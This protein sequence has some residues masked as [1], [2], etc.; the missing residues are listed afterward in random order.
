MTATLVRSWYPWVVGLSVLYLLSGCGS[1]TRRASQADSAEMAH[2][3]GNNRPS[4]GS[5]DDDDG[6]RAERA[7]RSD[8]GDFDRGESDRGD[9]RR[10]RAPA[11]MPFGDA[12][13]VSPRVRRRY[14]GERRVNADNFFDAPANEGSLWV[15]DGQGNYYFTKNRNRAIGDLITVVM[16]EP[17]VR[18]TLAEVK[19]TLS[20]AERKMELSFA[21]DRIKAKTL[22]DP[23]PPIMPVP[24][25][26]Y[27][28]E[29]KEG[30]KDERAPAVAVAPSP[31][32]SP[33]ASLSAEAAVAKQKEIEQMRRDKL[34]KMAKATM[35]D[36]DIVPYVGLKP[37]DTMLAEIVDRYPN[38]NFKIRG[39][40]KIPYRS[41]Y[42]LV[43]L[44][45]VVRGNDIN[46]SNDTV[47][48]GKLYEYR[49][50][51]LR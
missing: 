14:S 17:S 50:T 34:A 38:G 51:V 24:G 21:Q 4:M 44:L 36:V 18:E 23:E 32:P 46:E 28:A 9:E 27:V 39:T 1:P 31:S 35:T 22:G 40:K 13:N 11:G 45:G 15:L 48:S 16:E 5:S 8:R 29:K 41:G 49:L 30:A 43:T 12:E 26:A 25:S 10:M 3:Y 6:D 7:E 2:E 20:S 47:L 33:T 42:R 19:R 37:T